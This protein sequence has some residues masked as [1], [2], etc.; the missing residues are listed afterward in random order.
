MQGREEMS[1]SASYRQRGT[2]KPGRTLVSI[3]DLKATREGAMERSAWGRR[4]GSA[5]GQVTSN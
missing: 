2:G 5:E 1:Y 4:Q 3:E